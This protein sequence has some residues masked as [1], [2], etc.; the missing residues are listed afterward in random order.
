MSK[1]I[2]ACF[3]FDGTLTTSDSLLR[4]LW[5]AVSPQILICRSLQSGFLLLKYALGLIDNNRGKE[6]L[7][8]YLFARMEK[9][10][11]ILKSELF[12]KSILPSI[13]NDRALNKLNW[14]QKHG[15]EC[16]L[17]SASIEDYLVPWAVQ[18]GFSKVIGTRL[19]VDANG[20][21]TGKFLA[22]NCYGPEKV[23]RLE[24]YLGIL[25]QFEIYAYGDSRG[26][27]ELL[28]IADHPFYKSVHVENNPFTS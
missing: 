6:Q 11:F 19:A 1:R 8:S 5:F 10:D 28:G 25:D 21:L 13:L 20:L 2:I 27:K 3:D 18:A 22:K 4:F 7:F 17:I 12:S 26:D 23:R 14:H 9:E 16:V 24:E 15:H